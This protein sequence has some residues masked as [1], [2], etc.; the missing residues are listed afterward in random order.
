MQFTGIL[1]WIV[2]IDRIDVSCE[3]LMMLSCDAASRSGHLGAVMH[4]FACLSSHERSQIVIDNGYVPHIGK[5]KYKWKGFY[6]DAKGELPS[7]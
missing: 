1:C 2:E 7:N 6:S 3:V 4:I 5:V